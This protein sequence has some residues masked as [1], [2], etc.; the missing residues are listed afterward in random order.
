MMEE[1]KDPEK[2]FK[3]LEKYVQPQDEEITAAGQYP[4]LC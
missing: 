1:V 3:A 4:F 2:I